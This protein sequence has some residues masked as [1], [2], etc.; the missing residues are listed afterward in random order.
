MEEK[1]INQEKQEIKKPTYE[2]LNNFCNQL[3][4]QN[5]D[6]SRRLNEVG[7]ALTK[8]P[9]LFNVLNYNTLFDKDTVGRAV[10]EI[11]DLLFYD[12]PE[13]EAPK[14]QFLEPGKPNKK[15]EEEN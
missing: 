10:A 5:R 2:E 4:M 15:A 8:L 11:K 9:F 13:E 7:S 1:K 14:E 6:L 3:M 12:E